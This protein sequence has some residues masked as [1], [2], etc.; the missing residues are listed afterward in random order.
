MSGLMRAP[1]VPVS[2][3]PREHLLLIAM[4]AF[5]LVTVY[6]LIASCMP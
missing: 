3:D 5:W 2:D 6:L 4:I 1:E